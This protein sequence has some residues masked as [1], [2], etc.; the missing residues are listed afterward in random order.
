[1]SSI[2]RRLSFAVGL[3]SLAVPASASAAGGTGGALVP[4]EPEVVGAV[5]QDATAWQCAP[6]AMLTL[7]GDSLEEVRTVRFLGRR[8]RRDDRVTRPAS[9]ADR[10]L[11]VVVP[12]GARSGPVAV[13]SDVGRA[14]TPQPVRL[15]A[16]TLPRAALAAP[17]PADGVFPIDG[18]HDYGSETNRFGGGRDHGGQDVFARC[19]TPL[20][21]IYDATVQHRASHDRAGNY[22]VLQTADGAS[23]AYMHLQAPAPVRTGQV[24]EAGDPVGRVGDTGRASGCH[25]HFEQ[26]T[27]PG[28]YEGGTAVDPLPLLK[29]LDR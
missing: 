10:E 5:C 13:V 18:P 4:D 19:G 2:V 26:W 12:R 23:F 27:A 14:V 6:G 29:S 7:Q 15:T 25:L 22:V 3:L 16:G 24:V 1:M 20:V 8:G 21:A 11:T 28:W 9:T 17:A